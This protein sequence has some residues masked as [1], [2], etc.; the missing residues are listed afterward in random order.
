MQSA[1]ANT[2]INTS[3]SANQLVLTG[4]SLEQMLPLCQLQLQD[5]ALK[6]EQLPLWPLPHPSPSLH[7]WIAADPPANFAPEQLQ[8]LPIHG[9]TGK[10]TMSLQPNQSTLWSTIA[11]ADLSALST[12]GTGV[13]RS[14]Q[15]QPLMGSKHRSLDHLPLCGRVVTPGLGSADVW[16]LSGLGSRGLAQGIWGAEIIASHLLGQPIPASKERIKTV[17]PARLIRQL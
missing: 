5:G 15:I 9:I 8:G 11:P 13:A 17:S 16:L 14:A 12:L 1:K 2:S 7:S 6:S 3:I 4:N 10:G